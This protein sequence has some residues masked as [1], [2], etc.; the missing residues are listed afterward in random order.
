[1]NLS[2]CVPHGELCTS[3]YCLANPGHEYLCF[4]PSGGAEG[5][6]G[7]G[8]GG[9][10]VEVLGALGR[11]PRTVVILVLQQE[12]DAA[13]DRLLQLVRRHGGRR[14]GVEVRLFLGRLL[15][16]LGRGFPRLEQGRVQP[17][18][19]VAGTPVNDNPALENEAD[20][21][22][23]KAIAGLFDNGVSPVELVRQKDM[24]FGLEEGVDQCEDAMDVIRSV[25]VKNG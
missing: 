16:G 2:A 9:V 3:T 25:V 14:G 11:T 1:M 22:Y 17:T 23:R 10:D 6:V 4:F 13:A 18:L 8:H 20:A 7:P 19:S 21:V 12:G 24:L 15:R 5:L